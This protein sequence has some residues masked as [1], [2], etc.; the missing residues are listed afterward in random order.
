[1]K[2]VIARALVLEG[3]PVANT[4]HVER[5]SIETINKFLEN[6]R[7]YKKLPFG[8]GKTYYSSTESKVEPM[9]EVLL[10]YQQPH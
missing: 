10:L 6:P 3:H 5:L 8:A 4:H 9:A 1:M 7:A 2:T